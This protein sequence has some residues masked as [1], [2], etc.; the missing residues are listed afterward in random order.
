MHWQL[1][2]RKRPS[3]LIDDLGNIWDRFSLELKR[4]LGFEAPDTEFSNYAVVNFL[5]LWKSGHL[6]AVVRF[7]S[8]P[9]RSLRGPL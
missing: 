9:V 7:V 1:G 2:E 4:N 5:V 6:A 8:G 3:L